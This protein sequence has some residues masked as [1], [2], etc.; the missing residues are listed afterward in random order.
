MI[1]ENKNG[2]IDTINY[3]KVEYYVRIESQQFKSTLISLF[4]DLSTTEIVI[5]V[6]IRC[7]FNIKQKAKY[8]NISSRTVEKHRANIRKKMCLEKN[9]S[10]QK[11]ISSVNIQ[12]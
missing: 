3:E 7:N 11:F 10:L 8:L 9:V 1:E 6:L 5:C 12:K 4:P 2:L